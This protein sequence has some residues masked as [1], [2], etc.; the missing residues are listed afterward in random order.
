MSGYRRFIAYVYEYV[1]GKK[2]NGKGFI[3]VEARDGVCRMSYKLTGIYGKEIMPARIYAYVRKNNEC[4]GVFLGEC[5]LVGDNIQFEQEMEEENIGGSGYG[6][7]DLCGLVLISET[8]DMYGSGWDDKPLN[9]DEIRFPEEKILNVSG[10]GSEIKAAEEVEEQKVIPIRH[11]EEIKSEETDNK[12]LP[13]EEENSLRERSCSEKL[14]RPQPQMSIEPPQIEEQ[15]ESPMESM[16]RAEDTDEFRPF[17]DNG[18]FDCRKI[19]PEDFRSLGKRDRGLLENKFLRHGFSQHG[20]LILGRREE[21]NSYIL[22]VP[23]MYERQEALM[24][25]MFGFP[26]F[27]ETGMMTKSGRRSGYWYR[28]I[29]NPDMQM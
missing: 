12:I 25:S 26:Y 7:G 15:P 6:L 17:C 23:G 28:V 19:T 20:H 5:S 4:R 10:G 11:F 2:G 27:K 16:E 22:G 1:Q 3:R 14:S 24:A 21:D 8:G 29:D 9:F 18:I 13:E